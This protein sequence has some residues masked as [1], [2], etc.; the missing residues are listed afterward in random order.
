MP[1]GRR[2]AARD[3]LASS[4]SIPAL[5]V[6]CLCDDLRLSVSGER[7]FRA[8]GACVLAEPGLLRQNAEFPPVADI[9]GQ[10]VTLETAADHAALT[11]FNESLTPRVVH[12]EGDDQGR[13][14]EESHT[15]QT[16][17]L[18]IRPNTSFPRARTLHLEAE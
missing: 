4:H 9:E 5:A 12:S 13:R 3:A 16:C 18:R 10:P 11:I 1:F 15:S 2:T 17:R 6:G 14:F 7:I 8:K